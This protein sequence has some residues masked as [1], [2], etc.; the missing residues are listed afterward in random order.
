MAA[1]VCDVPAR[2]PAVD[3]LVA[4][5]S[6]DRL[7]ATVDKLVSFG[8]RHTM[9]DATSPDRGIGAA[10]NWL[11]DELAA[12]ATASGRSDITVELMSHTQ[13]PTENIPNPVD[14][15]NVV[16]I[17][18]G[19]ADGSNPLA[20]QRMIAILGHYDSRNADPHDASGDA[21]G[22]N[23]NASGVAVVLE[24]ARL[25]S[26]R[27]CDATTVFLMTAG[28]EQGL[29]GAQWFAKTALE[30]GWR[31]EAA[32]SNDIVGDPT[33]PA[34][35]EDRARVRVFSEGVPRH[36]SA[37]LLA[38]IREMGS[39][40]DSAS[41]Q[42]ARYM[43]DVAERHALPVKPWLIFRSDRFLRGG[44]HLAM[45]DHGFAAVRFTSVFE[46]LDRQQQNVSERDGQPYGD[47]AR[48][49]DANYLADVARLNA[50]AMF[51]LASSPAAPANARLIIARVAAD[52]IIRW[53]PNAEADLAGYEIVCRQSTSP[54]WE[55]V[56]DVG[57]VSEHTIDLSKDNWF[58]GVRA[59]DRDGF[60][61]LVSFPAAAPE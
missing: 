10:R 16:M 59:Y 32:L 13:P 38:Q 44:D 61:S 40:N 27:R 2:P 48:F 23:D 26:T 58:F 14:I 41:R 47:V 12:I 30:R 46:H 53:N 5:V 20:S 8:T 24:L 42:L 1:P 15:I 55:T 35:K 19:G 56:I 52:T 33:G 57:N 21:P 37:E 36:A 6:P 60:R 45:N 31:I 11:R 4:E 22:A 50:A 7:R 39:E 29:L 54:T 49:V 28:K 34:G 43:H 3:Q 25:L 9:S 18:P 17:I 51:S